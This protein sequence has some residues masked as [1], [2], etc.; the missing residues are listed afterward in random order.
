MSECSERVRR[1]IDEKKLPPWKLMFSDDCRQTLIDLTDRE[2]ETEAVK[3][4]AVMWIPPLRVAMTALLALWINGGKFADLKPTARE[5]WLSWLPLSEADDRTRPH[6]VVQQ[7]LWFATKD[8]DELSPIES[9]MLVD[10]LSRSTAPSI[11]A[12]PMAAVTVARAVGKKLLPIE[13]A[14]DYVKGHLG[15]DKAE[16]VVV[17]A[18]IDS[19]VSTYP[20]HTGMY[21]AAILRVLNRDVDATP[22]RDLVARDVLFDSE[23]KLRTHILANLGSRDEPEIGTG[24]AGT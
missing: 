6:A 7:V 11:K 20:E 19:I 22:L 10:R 23:E 8:L 13:Q 2:I 1:W 16:K 17:L 21:T 12:S 9:S 14:W 24:G 18:F 3:S 5:R 15:Y 4:P